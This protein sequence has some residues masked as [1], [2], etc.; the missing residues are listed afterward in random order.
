MGRRRSDKAYI[1]EEVS[2]WLADAEDSLKVAKD[3]LRLGNY[4]VTAFYLHS[5]LEK[6][7]KAAII[8]LRKKTPIKTH[9]LKRLCSEVDDQ[10]T[11][12][13]KQVDFLGELTPASQTSRYVDAALGIP[14]DVYSRRLVSRYLSMTEPILNKIRRPIKG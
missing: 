9:N 5:A 4:H 12:T 13:Q 1:R 11:L 7:F 14:R 10:I 8:A 6:A 3:N 2:L